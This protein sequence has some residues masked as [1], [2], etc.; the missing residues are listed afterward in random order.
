MATLVGDSILKRVYSK[1]PTRFNAESKQLCVGGAGAQA[2]KVLVKAMPPSGK[3]VLLVGINDILRKRDLKQAWQVYSSLVRTLIR[4]GCT[5]VCCLLLPLAHVMYSHLAP[6]V[7]QFNFWIK[8]LAQSPSVRLLDLY[9]AFLN[10]DKSVNLALYCAQSSRGIDYIHPNPAGLV[11][12]RDC[13]L[14]A[15]DD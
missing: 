10:P 15:V 4:R 14:R 9:S 2:I 8:S 13:I 11:I 6:S 5:V 12:L 1:Y 3:V 7:T